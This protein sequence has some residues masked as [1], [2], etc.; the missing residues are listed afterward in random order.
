MHQIT[1]SLSNPVKQSRTDTT[2]LTARPI[3]ALSHL[4][5]TCSNNYTLGNFYSGLECRKHLRDW[6]GSVT[7][8]YVRHSLSQFTSHCC[9]GISLL[10]AC[11]VHTA[12]Y[13]YWVAAAMSPLLIWYRRF[14]THG[15]NPSLILF[16]IYGFLYCSL[17][18]TTRGCREACTEYGS[19]SQADFFSHTH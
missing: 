13:K 19:V 18:I 6:C 1:N 8:V 15:W 10:V 7:F 3:S 12:G 17:S 5:L 16:C 11:S 9:I 2:W 14:T 4:H